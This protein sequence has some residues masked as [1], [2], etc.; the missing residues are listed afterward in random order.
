MIE[1][2]ISYPYYEKIREK[3]FSLQNHLEEIGVDRKS[4]HI[5]LVPENFIED[6]TGRVYLI[7][8]E[9]SAMNDPMW[10]LAALFLESNF[11]K[12]EE[13]EFFKAY[14]SEDTPVSVAK[15][16]IYKILQDF[17]WSLWTIYKEEQGAD[18]GSYG[19]DRYLR[20]VKNLKEYVES[21]EK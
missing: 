7:D 1:G 10:D 11:R 19:K 4:C 12:V 15:I 20:A 9:Y 21:Y 16:M 13:G 6:E 8:W 5:D 3:V 18:F 14:F 17:L 2:D